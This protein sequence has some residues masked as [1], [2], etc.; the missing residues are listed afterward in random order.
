[1]RCFLRAYQVDAYEPI[2][3]NLVG[4]IS[5]SDSRRSYFEELSQ[6]PEGLT[7][8]AVN[9]IR[10]QVQERIATQLGQFQVV[11]TH[12]ARVAIDGVPVIEDR[13]TQCGIYIVRNPLD[14]V[15]SLAD[16]TGQSLDDA[17]SAMDDW[18]YSFGGADRKFV[19]QYLT[20]WSNHV[21][22][23]TVN[24]PFPVLTIRYEDLLHSPEV[25]FQQALHF[26]GWPYDPKRLDRALKYSSFDVLSKS[27]Q[28][29]GFVEVSEHSK[30]NRFFRQGTADAWKG[31][32][33]EHQVARIVQAHRGV[34]Q[35]HNYLP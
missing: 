6:S 30:S 21:E 17:I 12:N 8:P 10:K 7:D 35:R 15:D 27:E 5:K 18:Q 13:L 28:V 24:P 11:K 3:L 34:M 29:H 31:N 19:R 14:V 20:T 23:W 26:L 22:T 1:M 32:L 16:H 25:Q 33:S 4:R 9:L 2:D